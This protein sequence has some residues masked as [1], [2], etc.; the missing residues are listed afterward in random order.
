MSV[1]FLNTSS[2]PGKV[3]LRSVENGYHWIK[4]CY[5]TFA[6]EFQ[7]FSVWG[8]YVFRTLKLTATPTD[9]ANQV[10]IG[11][12]LTNH[13][14][15]NF[16]DLRERTKTIRGQIA[17]FRD[18]FEKIKWLYLLFKGGI[19]TKNILKGLIWHWSSLCQLNFKPTG[20]N[21]LVGSKVQSDP[22]KTVWK[23]HAR[24]VLL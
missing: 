22:V 4:L 15:F 7:G 6:H 5:P 16:A 18:S 11:H 17:G 12:A 13:A 24:G 10:K 8:K 21:G 14:V 20:P 19:Q 23:K 1:H 9:I 2:F 3:H